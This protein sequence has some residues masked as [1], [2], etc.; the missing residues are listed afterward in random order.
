MGRERQVWRSKQR[1]LPARLRLNDRNRDLYCSRR[2]TMH[3]PLNI[4]SHPHCKSEIAALLLCH[5]DKVWNRFLGLCNDQKAALDKCLR[6]VYRL[7]ADRSRIPLV[8]SCQRRSLGR[9]SHD[10]VFTSRVCYRRRQSRS[11]S[12]CGEI[13]SRS[14]RAHIPAFPTQLLLQVG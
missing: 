2:T 12:L 5:S 4:S 10:S 14:F 9:A 7:T 1:S 11:K 8:G 6:E 13:G 3:P